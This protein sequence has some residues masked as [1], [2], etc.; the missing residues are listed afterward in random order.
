MPGWRGASPRFAAAVAQ[1]KDVCMLIDTHVHLQHPKYGPDLPSVLSRAAGAGV[2]AVI[3]PGT[4]LEDSTEALYLARRMSAPCKIRVAVGIH[5]TEAYLLDPAVIDSLAALAASGEVVA[6]GEIGLDYYWPRVAERTWR[7][8]DPATQRS[9]LERQLAL[10]SELRLPVVIHDRD[11][12]GDTIDI[13]R[14]WKARDPTARGTF[15]A[16]A[17]GADLLH[18]A[19]ELGFYIGIDGPV[20]FERALALH[21]VARQV[22]LDRLL[23]ETDGPYLTPVPHRGQRNEP[24]YLE[25]IAAR[26]AELR[27]A[28]LEDIAAATTENAGALFSL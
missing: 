22:P 1:W 13:L 20:T 19:L 26:V 11:A 10:A 23:L 27:G 17:A 24:A 25:H 4:T 28:R 14:A 12:H 21:E 15:H 8:A 5:P 7:C 18:E 16:Y 9:A 2:I 6:V 3:V